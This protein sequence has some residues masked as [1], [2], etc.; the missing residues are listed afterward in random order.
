MDDGGAENRPDVMVG[1]PPWA[2]AEKLMHEKKALGFYFSGH[3][4]DACRAELA[5]FIKTRLSDIAPQQQPVWLAGVIYA[6]RTQM[7]RRGKMAFISLEDGIARIE[8]SVFSELFDAHKDILKEDHTLIIEAKIS[9]DD[10]SG[11]FRVIAENLLDLAG[12]RTRFAKRLRLSLPASGNLDP[13]AAE[14]HAEAVTGKLRE[15]LSGYRDTAG[16]Q[17]RIGYSNATASCELELGED[18]RVMLKD[19]L[20][21]SLADCIGSENSAIQY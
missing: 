9:K 14:T 13:L 19:N 3:P 4:Y 15:I 1:A 6:I 2:L 17:V 18:W 5:G 16:C 7:T 10:Y 20:L 8:V 21:V 12:A 11:G